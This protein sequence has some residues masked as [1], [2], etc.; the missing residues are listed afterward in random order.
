M[1]WL[2]WNSLVIALV[3]VLIAAAT[4]VTAFQ[5]AGTPEAGTPV[6][7]SPSAAT[8]IAG[9]GSLVYAQPAALLSLLPQP[10]SESVV[11]IAQAPVRR[12]QVFV[13]IR[14]DTFAPVGEISVGVSVRDSTGALLAVGTSFRTIPANVEPGGLAQAVID[15]DGSAPDGSQAQTAITYGATGFALATPLPILEVDY[16]GSTLVGFVQSPGRAAAGSVQI[17]VSCW[18]A[19]GSFSD[20]APIQYI[21]SIVDQ[22]SLAS[23]GVDATGC[24]HFIITTG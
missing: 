2:A 21:N 5:P 12:N 24:D 19:E 6:G 7:G 4:S 10:G 3:L 1:R 17:A 11:V 16:T 8:P 9:T 14:N 15:L 20:Y 22:P 18:T 23:F 13:M